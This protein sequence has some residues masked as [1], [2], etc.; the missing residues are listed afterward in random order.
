MDEDLPRKDGILSAQFEHFF[1]QILLVPTPEQ[2]YSFTY[3]RQAKL[4]STSG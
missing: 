1:F 3:V 4:A 2:M